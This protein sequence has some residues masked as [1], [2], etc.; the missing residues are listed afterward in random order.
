[1]NAGGRKATALPDDGVFP[2]TDRLP[3]VVLNYGNADGTS[4]QTRTVRGA[5]EFAFTV[6]PR[7][8]QKVF[9]FLSAAP[10]LWTDIVVTAVYQDGG[11]RS[12]ATKVPE[13]SLRVQRPL[14]DPAWSVLASDIGKWD[15][16][17]ACRESGKHFIDALDIGVDPARVLLRIRISSRPGSSDAN[18]TF[19]GATGITAADP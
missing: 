1:V 4:P 18:L 2:A 19:W 5:G 12:V 14:A 15:A 8:Y 16:S 6:P 11:E 10:V 17:N 7:S 3:R 13:F 9:I